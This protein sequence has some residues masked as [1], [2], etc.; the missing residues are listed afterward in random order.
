MSD[1]MRQSLVNK[2]NAVEALAVPD[3]IKQQVRKEV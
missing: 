3:F 1:M 2:V